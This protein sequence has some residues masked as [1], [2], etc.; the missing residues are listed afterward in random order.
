MATEHFSGTKLIVGDVDRAGRFYQSVC[1]LIEEQRI[2]TVL[3]GRAIIEIIFRPTA[4]DG[5][6]LI[7]LSF[8]DTPKP[9]AGG[10]VLMMYTTDLKAFVQRAKEAG[11]SMFLDI[12]SYPEYGLQTAYVKDLDGHFIQAIEKI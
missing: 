6:T 1:G 3:A 9:P 4:P 11:G 12:V 2:D 10:A 7:L 5:A 8:L